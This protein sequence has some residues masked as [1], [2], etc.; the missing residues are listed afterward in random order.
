MPQSNCQVGIEGNLITVTLPGTN[1]R[2]LFRLS[3]DEPRLIQDSQLTVD[4]AAPMSHQDF[5]AMAWE[6]AN[7]KAKEVGWL[8]AGQ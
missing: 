4:K 3:P 2:A 6:A 1:Y 8:E 5:E 7:A